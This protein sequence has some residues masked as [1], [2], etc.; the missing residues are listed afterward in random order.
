M[1][2]HWYSAAHAGELS[3]TIRKDLKD[4]IKIGC[5]KSQKAD[6]NNKQFPL[7][8]IQEYCD[9]SATAISQKITSEEFEYFKA[10]EA[11]PKGFMDRNREEGFKCMEHLSVKWKSGK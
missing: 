8:K 1:Y 3:Y 9:C 4:V 10:N 2:G 6:P 7:W 11:W 5:I